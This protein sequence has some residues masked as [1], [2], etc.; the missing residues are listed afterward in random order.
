MAAKIVGF[1]MHAVSKKTGI[2]VT[3]NDW[4]HKDMFRN[5]CMDAAVRLG[6]DDPET[7]MTK[8]QASKFMRGKGIVYET[9]MKD[10]LKK[11]EPKPEIT[12]KITVGTGAKK[13]E[14]EAPQVLTQ[15]FTFI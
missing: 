3:A 1:N 10:G 15:A 7:L 4:A 13:V 2:C 8:R 5:A 12:R 9:I 6:I 14:A 11:P